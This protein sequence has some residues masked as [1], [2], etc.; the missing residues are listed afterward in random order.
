M[1][2]YY[3]IKDGVAQ[4]F[5]PLKK[6][7]TPYQRITKKMAFE[8]GAVQGTTDTLK[9]LGDTGG[10]L[11]WKGNLGIKAGQ[12]FPSDLQKAK[13]RLEE[14]STEAAQRGTD[15]H[16]YIDQY[17]TKGLMPDDAQGLTACLEVKRWLDEQAVTDFRCEHCFVWRG[18]INITNGNYAERMQ[19]SSLCEAEHLGYIKV[20]TGGTSDFVSDGLICD[21]KTVEDKGYGFRGSYAKEAAQ[22]AMYRLGFGKHKARCV[23]LYVDRTTGKIVRVKE[24]TE[25]ELM[26]GLRLFAMASLYT[27]IAERL[28][29]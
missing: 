27:D 21:W 15:I 16:D 2:H 10:L 9:V 13:G 24:W 3:Q 11:V 19:Q 20:E 23:N 29:A 5:A 12:E 22:M 28:E 6:D 1:A 14:L 8:A 7:G 17:L 25:A 18:W 4:R 26:D